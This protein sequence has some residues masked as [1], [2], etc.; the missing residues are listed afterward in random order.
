MEEGTAV[1]WSNYRA[2]QRVRNLCIGIAHVDDR[3]L[4]KALAAFP[5][6]E[7]LSVLVDEPEGEWPSIGDTVALADWQLSPRIR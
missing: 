2:G 5:A 4:V 6:V 3:S 1:D 7:R